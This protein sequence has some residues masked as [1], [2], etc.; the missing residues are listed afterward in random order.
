MWRNRPSILEL[1][2]QNPIGSEI[3]QRAAQLRDC[4]TVDG[5]SLTSG[6]SRE[7]WLEKLKGFLK[8]FVHRKCTPEM[9]IRNAYSWASPLINYHMFYYFDDF[10]ISFFDQI[11]KAFQN[12]R[13]EMVWKDISD[14][15][16]TLGMEYINSPKPP[17]VRGTTAQLL[18]AANRGEVEKHLRKKVRGVVFRDATRLDVHQKVS[19]QKKFHEPLPAALRPERY[20][21]G[22]LKTPKG[23]TIDEYRDVEELLLAARDA[24]RGHYNLLKYANILHRDIS[25][26]NIIIADDPEK[27]DGVYGVLIDLHHARDL[28]E[29]MSPVEACQRTG[30]LRFMSNEVLDGREHTHIHDLHS[31]LYV[32]VWLCVDEAWYREEICGD[33]PGPP[34]SPCDKWIGPDLAAIA[35][36]KRSDM[37]LVCHF[38]RLLNCMPDS[39]RRIQQVCRGMREILYGPYGYTFRVRGENKEMIYGRIDAVFERAIEDEERGRLVRLV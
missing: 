1:H 19:T 34:Q 12:T 16:Y 28:S 22:F 32:L 26:N 33:Q 24:I 2:A 13:D 25:P 29:P 7:D 38:G 35:R 6:V 9:Q 4:I 30:T 18:A 15:C 20:L 5:A 36:A 3:R 8:D 21:R 14:A 11:L 27:A 31:F 17:S 37:A 10:D 39:L 23:R